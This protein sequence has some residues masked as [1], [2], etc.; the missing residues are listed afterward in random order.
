[1]KE[2]SFISFFIIQSIFCFCQDCGE[3]NLFNFTNIVLTEEWNWDEP[4]NGFYFDMSYDTLTAPNTGYISFYL[5]ND[6]NDTI[7]VKDYHEW[8]R[9]FPLTAN[10]TLRYTMVLD[11]TYTSL[12]QD[13][14][15]FLITSNPQCQIPISLITSLSKDEISNEKINVF[16]N[17][18]SGILFLEQK[19]EDISVYDIQGTV[20]KSKHNGNSIDLTSLSSG[21]YFLRA[22][23]NDTHHLSKIVKK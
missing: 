22:I 23:N 19:F 8:S 2:T 12:P 4:K 1:M 11:S 9:S 6:N 17:P 20:V 15:G 13:F 14:S 3:F 5:V 18:T 16:P 10:D 21:I 7:T